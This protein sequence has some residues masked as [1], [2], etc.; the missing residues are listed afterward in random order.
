MKVLSRYALSLLLLTSCI[1]GG[2]L[3]LD[4]QQFLVEPGDNVLE[5]AL[6]EYHHYY[7]RDCQD[8]ILD[9]YMSPFYK[10]Y[11][12]SDSDETIRYGGAFLKGQ[13]NFGDFW[14]RTTTSFGNIKQV[15]RDTNF[16]DIFSRDNKNSKFGIEDVLIKAGYDVYF[17]CDD[18]LNVYFLA[19][20]PTHKNQ[21]ALLLT[22]K[23]EK[24]SILTLESPTLSSR[25]YRVGV[26]TNAAFAFYD[27]DDHHSAFLIDL[28]YRYALP[29][30]YTHTEERFS[31][32]PSNAIG[33]SRADTINFKFTPGH[34]VNVWTALHHS[35]DCFNFE[36]GSA[37]ATTFGSKSE[38]FKAEQTPATT[39]ATETAG[40]AKPAAAPTPFDDF[41]VVTP[42]TVRFTAQPYVAVSYND[43][44]CD[45]PVTLGL[46][47][48]YNFMQLHGEN[49]PKLNGVTA[50]LTAGINF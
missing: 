26:G 44:A 13:L 49:A 39:P 3:T 48:G 14:L 25:N 16:T 12:V 2:T 38:F 5:Y 28:Q 29:S 20:L 32:D 6:T 37:F 19:G 35:Y 8:H 30:V 10:H 23:T 1:K 33:Q 17:N 7:P 40:S 24:L 46:G 18:H 27:C 15:H 9:L 34:T 36:I 4:K 42:N 41:K 50:W 45:Y 21:G 22:D 31:D 47:V 11:N 43:V